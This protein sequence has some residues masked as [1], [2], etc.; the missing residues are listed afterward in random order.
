[1]IPALLLALL[2]WGAADLYLGLT[3]LRR[4]RE[5]DRLSRLLAR[6]AERDARRGQP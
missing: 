5:A 4:E 3:A 6:V 2:A 1:M